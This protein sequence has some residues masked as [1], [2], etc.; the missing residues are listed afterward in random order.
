MNIRPGMPASSRLVSDARAQLNQTEHVPGEVILGLRGGPSL[1][2]ES[3]FGGA[4]IERF[5]FGPGLLSGSEASDI[6]RVRLDDGADMAEALAQLRSLPEVAYAEV[7]E[8][9]HQP[10]EPA[11]SKTHPSPTANPRHT[12]C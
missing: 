11:E 7:N 6:V 9:L 5:D 3:R 10:A 4:V 12:T 8:I 1:A 2:D